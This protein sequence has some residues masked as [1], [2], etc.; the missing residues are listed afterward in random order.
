MGSTC[1]WEEILDHVSQEKWEVDYKDYVMEC[2]CS[3]RY[4]GSEDKQADTELHSI[5]QNQGKMSARNAN[6]GRIKA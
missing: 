1:N 5:D 6:N 2:S 4:F 3:T